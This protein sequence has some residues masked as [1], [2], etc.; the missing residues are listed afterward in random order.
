MESF[1]HDNLT[2]EVTDLGPADGEAVI[3]LHGFPADRHS[4]DAVAGRLVAADLRILAPDQRGYSPEAR[5]TTRAAYRPEALA[6]DVLALADQAGVDRFHI[7][8]HDWG[9]VVAW[10]L[11]AADPDRVATLTAVSVP[12]PAAMAHAWRTSTQ[13]LRSWYMVA[14]QVPVLPELALSWHQGAAVA[15][16]LRASG[17]GTE[18]AERYASRAARPGGFTG[19]LGWYRALPL[20]SAIGAT[21]VRVPTVMI[22][23]PG[24]QF[25]GRGAAE[26]AA[27]W[28]RASYRF[29]EVAGG[30]HWLPEEAPGAV[31]D[32]V[33]DLV[34]AHPT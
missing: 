16:A 17:L 34:R 31:A 8:G 18:A 15:R 24:D 6:S 30:D 27:A 2:F 5:P 22:W 19:P 25:I 13:V 21:A 7:V 26:R 1:T 32:A 11:A 14:F 28:V 3:L 12:H 10:Y 23:A 33:I 29:V 9:A 20:G 4:W